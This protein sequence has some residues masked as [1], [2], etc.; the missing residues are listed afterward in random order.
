MPD[1]A[2]DAPAAPGVAAD[3]WDSHANVLS[4]KGCMSPQRWPPQGLGTLVAWC[5][6]LA[7]SVVCLTECGTREHGIVPD[8]AADAPAPPGVAAE[9]WDSHANVLS[10]RGCVWPQRWPP[11]G[12][13]A[14]CSSLALSVVCVTECGTVS[15]ASCLTVLP[16][17][18]QLLVSWLKC[19]TAMPPSPPGWPTGE[20]S[21]FRSIGR[22]KLLWR[23]SLRRHPSFVAQHVGMAVPR[24]SHDTSTCRNV[25]S[26]INC[27]AQSH[28]QR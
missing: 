8:G 21:H 1:G 14:C 23:P 19:R 15:M 4:N 26:T 6:S 7:L 3:A 22:N 10:N 17:L 2:A 20:L 5:S 11:R 9:A 28:S 25:G 13:V 12:L 27:H 16:T 24:F 18:L